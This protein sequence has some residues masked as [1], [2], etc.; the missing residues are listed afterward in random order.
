[1]FKKHSPLQSLSKSITP[2]LVLHGERDSKIPLEQGYELYYGLKGMGV[3]TRMIIYPREG[4]VLQ[5]P[6]HQLDY[7]EQVLAWYDKYLKQ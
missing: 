2:T 7:L 5:E 4:H 3:D 6:A 1:M